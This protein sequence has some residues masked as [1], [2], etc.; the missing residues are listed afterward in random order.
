MNKI[1]FALFT[2][3][4]MKCW[5]L[6]CRLRVEAV[7]GHSGREVKGIPLGTMTTVQVLRSL[8]FQNSVNGKS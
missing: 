2:F 4:R 5:G 8:A 7:E 6:Q 1:I 3:K